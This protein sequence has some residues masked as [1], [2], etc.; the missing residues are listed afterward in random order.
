MLLFV[1]VFSSTHR[2]CFPIFFSFFLVFS[3]LSICTLVFHSLSFSISLCCC[4]CSIVSCSFHATK[5]RFF[6]SPNHHHHQHHLVIVIMYAW[7]R[8]YVGI[9]S[10]FCVVLIVF[11]F[12]FSSSFSTLFVRLLLQGSR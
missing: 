9:Y 4:C 10:V 1:V 2:V 6:S 5:Q 7:R 8:L 11:C 3:A 12:G